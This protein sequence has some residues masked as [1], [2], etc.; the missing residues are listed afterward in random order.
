MAK[1][2]DEWNSTML[3][4]QSDVNS[5]PLGYA[6]DIADHFGLQRPTPPPRQ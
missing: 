6:D 2:W 4:D 3:P 1:A 5:G